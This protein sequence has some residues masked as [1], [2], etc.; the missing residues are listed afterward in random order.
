MHT[1]LLLSLS[2]TALLLSGGAALAET[3]TGHATAVITQPITITETT[4][5][6]FGKIVSD[7]TGG[8]VTVSSAGVI[9][10][11]GPV[12]Y[13]TGSQGVFTIAAEPSTAMTITFTAGTLDDGASHTMPVNNFT[14]TTT[15]AANT[16]DALGALQ[17]DASASLVVAANQSAGTYTGTYGIT[18][19]Y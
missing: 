15:P 9:S 10:S 11:S 2:L 16:T 14:Y 13:G 6:N 17:I 3:A 8:T 5:M 1:K 7:A 4:Q 19:N 12:T 18:V